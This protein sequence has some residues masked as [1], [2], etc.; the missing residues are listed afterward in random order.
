MGN[1]GRDIW[2]EKPSFISK[3][4]DA[5]RKERGKKKRKKRKRPSYSF[6]AGDRREKGR[7]KKGGGRILI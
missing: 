6:S 4:I 3:A 1:E 5:G 2:K 7:K